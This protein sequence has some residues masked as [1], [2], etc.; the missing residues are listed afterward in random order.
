MSK[1][2]VFIPSEDTSNFVDEIE[3]DFTW[4]SGFSISQKQK[5]IESLHKEITNKTGLKS[6]LEISTKSLDLVGVNASAFNLCLTSK[7]GTFASVESFYQGSKVFQGG[8]PYTDLYKKNSYDA[9]KDER[10]KNS[11]ELTGF[12]FKGTQWGLN[13]FFYDWLYMNALQ[14]NI[15]IGEKFKKYDGFTDIEFNPKKSYNCQAYSAALF[16]SASMK[17]INIDE[18]KSKQVFQKLFPAKKLKNFQLDLF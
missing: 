9:K 15:E 18:L 16:V 17:G 2:P 12:L 6:I 11:G 1:R 3:I 5:S 8:G 4:H 7:D 13:D 14:Q 10:L